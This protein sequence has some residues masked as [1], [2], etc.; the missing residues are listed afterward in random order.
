[1]SDKCLYHKKSKDFGGIKTF[2]YH[3]SGLSKKCVAVD[4][5]FLSFYGKIVVDRIEWLEQGTRSRRKNLQCS[6]LESSFFYFE[7][8]G[9]IVL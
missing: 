6:F 1:M 4:F 5:L 2:I 7:K 9:I 3:F 8:N